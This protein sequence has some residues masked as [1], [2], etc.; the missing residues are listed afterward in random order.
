LWSN[1]SIDEN[2][3]IDPIMNAKMH[4]EIVVHI[5]KQGIGKVG[6]SFETFGQVVRKGSFKRKNV[7]NQRH[8]PIKRQL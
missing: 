6:P 2:A 3:T 8:K 1:T 4:V 5:L 7:K